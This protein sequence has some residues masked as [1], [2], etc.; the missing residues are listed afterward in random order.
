MRPLIPPGVGGTGGPSTGSEVAR[1]LLIKNCYCFG[2]TYAYISDE[3]VSSLAVEHDPL[4]RM[5]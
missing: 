1:K 2:I 4:R 3:A 5:T